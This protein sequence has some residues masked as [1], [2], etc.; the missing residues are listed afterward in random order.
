MNLE[1]KILWVDDKIND[2]SEPDFK[3]DIENHLKALFF[4]P[5]LHPCETVEEAKVLID[6]NKYDLILSDYNIDTEK[7]D[8]FIRYV[9]DKNVITEILFYTAQK[10]LPRPEQD[11]ISFFKATGPGWHFDFLETIK[12]I[13]SLTVEKLQELTVIRGLVM[14]ETSQLDKLMEDI[15]LHYFVTQEN[16]ERNVIFIEIL[17]SLEADYKKRLKKSKDGCKDDCVH[18]LREKQKH[19]IITSMDFDSS[20]KA[21]TINTIIKKQNFDYKATR[22]NF[23]ED[24]REEIIYVRNDLAHSHSEQKKGVEVLITTRQKNEIVFDETTFKEIR[25]NILKFSD[26]INDLKSD[27][28]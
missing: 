15:I 16:L 11:R 2:T 19:E 9:R 4:L 3:P 21:R 12:R 18:S 17:N 5:I 28:G 1:Y 25:Q 8:A 10:D 22:Q 6:S 14:A 23:Y 26:V 20:R 27:L 24:Y 13:I 7:G